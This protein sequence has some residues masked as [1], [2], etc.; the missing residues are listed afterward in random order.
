MQPS[1]LVVRSL[2]TSY[3]I[4]DSNP[5]SGSDIQNKS[6]ITLNIG[7]S[8]IKSSSQGTIVV[9]LLFNIL[10]RFTFNR[11]LYYQS[12]VQDFIHSLFN[13]L[14]V[15]TSFGPTEAPNQEQSFTI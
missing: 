5:D 9:S 8:L 7:P 4:S 12:S 13:I 14:P 15:H 3:E 6:D 1:S 2:T 10:Q 11:L